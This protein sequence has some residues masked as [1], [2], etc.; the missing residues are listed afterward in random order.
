M[1]NAKP[2]FVEN[3]RTYANYKKFVQ[4]ID[5]LNYEDLLSLMVVYKAAY[6]R[7]HWKTCAIIDTYDIK[8][9]TSLLRSRGFE[10]ERFS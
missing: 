3:E 9:E 8:E 5:L 2:Y 6:G 7:H 1:S 10:P 4:L